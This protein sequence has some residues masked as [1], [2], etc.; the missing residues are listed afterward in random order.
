MPGAAVQ[1]SVVLAQWCSMRVCAPASSC[2]AMIF[3][4]R[5]SSSQF[6]L[7]PQVFNEAP[8]LECANQ[9]SDQISD[10]DRGLN[11]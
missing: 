2:R 1:V 6:M 11:W 7:R 10:I 5:S 4:S 8:F 9:T 3:S